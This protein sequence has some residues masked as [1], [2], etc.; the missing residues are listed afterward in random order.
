[1]TLTHTAAAERDT[2]RTRLRARTFGVADLLI[3]ATSFVALLAIGLAYAGRLSVFDAS[4]AQHAGVRTINLNTVSSA[5][6]IEPAL[7]ATFANAADR[8]S[9]QSNCSGSSKP[10]GRPAAPHRMSA[11]SAARPSGPT[12][13]YA[14]SVSS[15]FWRGGRRSC[16]RPHGRA[17]G[18][19][20]PR[21]SPLMWGPALAGP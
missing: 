3:V 19:C 7:A 13:S 4:D 16:A 5:A 17:A 21:L 15:S 10:S 9:L 11:P 2:R 14:R 6:E 1:M 18:A 20:P 12:R 8:R